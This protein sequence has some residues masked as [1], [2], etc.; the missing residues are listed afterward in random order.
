MNIFIEI[1][2]IGNPESSQKARHHSL[3][4]HQTMDK[5]LKTL[6]FHSRYNCRDYFRINMGLINRPFWFP[7]KMT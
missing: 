7:C 5:E 6:A 1:E 3:T 2:N 4:K